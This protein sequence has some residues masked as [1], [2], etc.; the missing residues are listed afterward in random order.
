MMMTI[1]M[2]GQATVDEGRIAERKRSGR[3]SVVRVMPYENWIGWHLIC[4]ATTAYIGARIVINFNLNKVQYMD[5]WLFSSPWSRSQQP[6]RF[7]VTTN[8][9]ELWLFGCSWFWMFCGLLL[10]ALLQLSPPSLLK[11]GQLYSRSVQAGKPHKIHW[12]LL[13]SSCSNTFE[14]FLL[15]KKLIQFFLLPLSGLS[16]WKS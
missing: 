11:A 6:V 8:E 2:G 5:I 9:E 16:F 15:T 10:T 13:F 14:T 12:S 4:M 1:M 3:V 7:G